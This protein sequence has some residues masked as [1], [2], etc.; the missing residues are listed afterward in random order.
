MI[1]VSE[2]TLK[3]DAIGIEELTDCKYYYVGNI[4]KHIY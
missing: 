3:L 1:R 4:E 2:A